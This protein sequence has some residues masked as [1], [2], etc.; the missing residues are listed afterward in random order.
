MNNTA[1]TLEGRLEHITFH[2]PD[3][4]YTIARLRPRDGGRVTIVGY[5]AAVRPGESLTIQGVWEQHPRFGQQFRIQTYTVTLPA[6]VDGIRNYLE[7]GFVKGIGP[8]MARRL[9]RHFGS[10]TLDVI[11]TSPDRLTE[12]SGI[13]AVKA[14]RIVTA[15]QTHHAVRDLMAF[16]QKNDIKIAYSARILKAYGADAVKILSTDPFRAAADIPGI[17]FIVADKIARHRDTPADVPGR[18]KACARYLLEQAAA[19]GHTFL[20]ATVLAEQCENLF[21][22][23]P[24]ELETALAALAEDNEITIETPSGAPDTRAVYLKPLHTAETGIAAKLAALLS[25][26]LHLPDLAPEQI[27]TEILQKLAIQ[28]SDEQ[29]TVLHGLLAHRVAVI[30]G[31]PGTGK[32]TLV[33]SIGAI[34]G[35]RGKKILLAAPTGRAARRLSEV[36]GRKAATLHKLLGYNLTTGLFDKDRDDPLET[37]VLIV[38]EA[39]MVDTLLMHHLLSAVPMRCVLILVGDVFQL[40][41]VGPGN[42]LSDLIKSKAL[43]VFY[44]R[45]VFRQAQESPIIMNAHR[46]RRGE[47]PLFERPDESSGLSEFYFIEQRNPARVVATIADLCTRAIPGRFSLDPVRDIQVLT[48]M[49]KGEVGTINLNQ[50]LQKKL[51]PA[52]TD[53]PGQTDRFKTGDKVMHLRNNYQKEVFNGDIGV[54]SAIDAARESLTVD[55]DGRIVNYDFAELDELALAYAISVHKSQGSEYPAV[56]VPLMT[57]HYALLQ[58]NLL[59]TAATRGQQLVILIGMPRALEI[60]LKNDRPAQRLS[61]LADKIRQHSI[62]TEALPGVTSALD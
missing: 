29:M 1:A 58:R 45:T 13:G 32:T 7:S 14:D 19:E 22:I 16:L 37:D 10:Q 17:G 27:T 49:H 52:G 48:P 11:E 15:W 47:P 46:I 31:G 53:S 8:A 59:Y 51:N 56:I 28:L 9:I 40:P 54:I 6:S 24:D 3:N 35:G 4:H 21:Q 55:Y 36:T 44:L 20:P 62:Y 43:P 12:V 18:N 33:R 42:V 5:M 57:Q 30:T 34:F 60:A 38:D 39:S 25:V 2:N 41:A 23:E 61:A 26:P 50:V